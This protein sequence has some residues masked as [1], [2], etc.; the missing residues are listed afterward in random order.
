MKIETQED[1]VEGGPGQN[2]WKVNV[3]ITPRRLRAGTKSLSVVVEDG[4]GQCLLRVA[5]GEREGRPLMKRNHQ[6][7]RDTR[8]GRYL[9]RR[10]TVQE[11]K[12]QNV[13]KDCDQLLLVTTKDEAVD[14]SC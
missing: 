10:G 9:E 5:I 2:L 3:V 13:M 14:V 12:D 7:I 1:H 4:R 8:G 11:T 6:D